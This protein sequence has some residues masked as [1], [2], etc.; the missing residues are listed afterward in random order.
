MLTNL[1]IALT[2]FLARPSMYFT[3]QRIL[4]IGSG[5][6]RLAPIERMMVKS[7]GIWRIAECTYELFWLAISWEY[8]YKFNFDKLWT[9]ESYNCVHIILPKS[10]CNTNLCNVFQDMCYSVIPSNCFILSSNFTSACWYTHFYVSR[11]SLYKNYHSLFDVF[12]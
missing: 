4:C 12:T 1:K 10:K 8:L 11:F 2:D 3:Q 7:P 9:G 5:R 6:R